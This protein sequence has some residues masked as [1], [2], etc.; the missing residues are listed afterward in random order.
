MRAEI[1]IY[2]GIYL[3]LGIFIGNAGLFQVLIYWQFLRMLYMVNGYTKWGFGRLSK[4]MDRL[5]GHPS[6]PGI[7]RTLVQKIK[8]GAA[9]MTQMEQGQAGGGPRCAIF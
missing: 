3:I 5:A 9:W 6:C 7:V 2:S 1:E 4:S 8:G